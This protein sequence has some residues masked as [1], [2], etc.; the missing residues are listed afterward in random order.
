MNAIETSELGKRYRPNIWALHDC[1]MAIPTERIIALVGPNGAGKTTL[2][3]LAVGLVKAT[4]GSVTVLGGVPA[5]SLEAL[6]RIAF[7][8][9]DAPLY[10][11]LSVA[12]M[13]DVAGNMNRHFDWPRAKD[14][15]ADLGIALGHKVGKLSGGQ[16]AQLA[17]TIAFSRHPDLLVLDEPLSGLDPLARHDFLASLMIAVAE[18]NL[19]VVFSSHVISELERVADYLVVLSGGQV[20]VMGEISQLVAGHAIVSGPPSDADRIAARFAVVQRQQA[21]RQTQL[22]IRTG[23]SPG[24]VPDGWESA[25]VTLEEL[26]LAYLREPSACA[27]PG[28]AAVATP[29]AK[30]GRA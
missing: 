10:G 4:T 21:G 19:S 16:R 24:V 28:P 8:A 7:V 23:N 27:L 22:L 26:V 3:H 9:Q 20:Q 13:L 2:L 6:D 25:A 30:G 14:R 11:N 1:T 17:L 15:L 12:E 5:G 18:D 29:F